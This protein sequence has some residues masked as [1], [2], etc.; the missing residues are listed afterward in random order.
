MATASDRLANRV[1]A[2]IGVIVARIKRQ[3]RQEGVSHEQMAV[4]AEMLALELG[5]KDELAGDD[6]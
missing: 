1:H 5:E 6:S 3:R 2:T 4:A